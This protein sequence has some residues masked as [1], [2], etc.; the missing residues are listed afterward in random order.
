MDAVNEGTQPSPNIIIIMAGTNDAWFRD[1]RPH[2]FD[3]I[4]GHASE[5]DKN[6]VG[7]ASERDKNVVGHASKRDETDDMVS[8]CGAVRHGCGMLKNAFP[9]ARVVLVTPMQSTAVPDSIIAVASDIIEDTGQQMGLS[10]LRLDRDGCV[11]SEQERLNKQFTYDGTH[12]NEQGAQCTAR[13]IVD[14]INN[15]GAER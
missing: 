11:V 8:L 9:A 14:F 10:V 3:N 6:V 12:T 5:R 1:K 15:V 13:L 7:H 2:A 4:V